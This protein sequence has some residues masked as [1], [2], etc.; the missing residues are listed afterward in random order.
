MV[1]MVKWYFLS[2]F[3][4]PSLFCFLTPG[5]GFPHSLLLS[6]R[7]WASRL[8]VPLSKGRTTSCSCVCLCVIALFCSQFSTLPQPAHT[9]LSGNT[10]VILLSYHLPFCLQFS[11]LFSSS[12]LSFLPLKLMPSLFLSSLLHPQAVPAA[13]TSSSVFLI[14]SLS[15]CPPQLYPSTRLFCSSAVSSF[16]MPR[17][18][19]LSLQTL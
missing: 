5:L 2:N 15:F 11:T 17:F 14:P 6:H 3:F 9:V 19:C 4:F 13:H 8:S 16:P 18:N 7:L 12:F 10:S 1:N